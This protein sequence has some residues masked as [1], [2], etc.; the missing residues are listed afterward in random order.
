MAGVDEKL[1]VPEDVV[2]ELKKAN[3]LRG[4]RGR[5]VGASVGH[6]YATSVNSH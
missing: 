5:G 4:S 3:T 2:G 1:P 6:L